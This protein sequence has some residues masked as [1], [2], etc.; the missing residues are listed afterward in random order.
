MS[1]SR[2]EVISISIMLGV[3]AHPKPGKRGTPISYPI[4]HAVFICSSIP[5]TN[6]CC[7]CLRFALCFTFALAISSLCCLQAGAYLTLSTVVGC[8]RTICIQI[9]EFPSPKTKELNLSLSQPCFKLA[10]F[11]FKPLLTYRFHSSFSVLRSTSTSCRTISLRPSVH[12]CQ[13]A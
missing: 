3:R 10:S 13:L 5:I 1:V 7:L 4:F 8:Y 9:I 11:D 12:L 2:V 6:A